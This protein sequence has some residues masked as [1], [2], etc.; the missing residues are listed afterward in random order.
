MKRRSSRSRSVT[1]VEQ[2][3][4]FIGLEPVKVEIEHD[5]SPD[6]MRHIVSLRMPDQLLEREPGMATPTVDL[7][8]QRVDNYASGFL[9]AGARQVFAFGWNQRLNFPHALAM[10]DSTM[11]ELFNARAG[12]TPAGFVGWRD[13]MFDSARTPAAWPPSRAV[14]SSYSGCPLMTSSGEKNREKC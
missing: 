7:A 9:A 10:S 12:G 1:P 3:S 11:G 4:A 5:A 13:T 6:T 14:L 8:R 2:L